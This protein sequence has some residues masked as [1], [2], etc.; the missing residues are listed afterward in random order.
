M[1][2]FIDGTSHSVLVGS[3][4]PTAKIPWTKPQDVPF[5]DTSPGI[6]KKGG[7]AAPFHAKAGKAGLF[8]RAD[9]SVA[10]IRQDIDKEL[11]RRLLTINDR[12]VVTP[13]P[14]IDPP[15]L[16]ARRRKVAVIEIRRTGKE[17]QARLMFEIDERRRPGSGRT[18]SAP[19]A[20]APKTS[21]GADADSRE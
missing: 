15:G 3:V 7:F 19:S 8:L 14:T 18:G 21:D 5:G 1:R 11:L 17:V 13:A 9:G 4:S 10:T 16:Q 2:Q 20:S 12:Q 6:G